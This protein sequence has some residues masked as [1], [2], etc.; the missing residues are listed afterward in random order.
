MRMQ[1][2]SPYYMTDSFM[3]PLR[4][5]RL[6]P[7][8]KPLGFCKLNHIEYVAIKTGKVEFVQLVN[9]CAHHK[10]APYRK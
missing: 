7:K 2:T 9:T 6:E 5:T 4:V 10:A 1:F 3:E 8:M